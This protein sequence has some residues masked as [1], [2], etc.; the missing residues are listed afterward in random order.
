MVKRKQKIGL[1]LGAGSA[2][3]LAHIGVLKVLEE[4]KIPVDYLAGTSMGALIGAF[5]ATGRGVE[6]M[7]E[8]ATGVDLKLMARLFAPTFSTSGLIEGKRIKEFLSPFLKGFNFQT[9]KIPFAALATD[10]RTGREVVLKEG[11]LVEAV[12]ASISIPIIFTPVRYRGRY[13]ID[14]GTVN[15]VPVNVARKL[16]A[17]LVIAVNVVNQPSRKQPSRRQDS[18]PVSLNPPSESSPL[19]LLHRKINRFIQE[20]NWPKAAELNRIIFPPGG[21]KEGSPNIVDI[22]MQTLSIY[23]YEVARLRLLHDR[24][25]ILIEPDTSSIKT[26]DYHRAAEAIEIGEKAA[27]KALPKI[28]KA[29]S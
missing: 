26:R 7:E 18:P 24:P 8:I 12:R 29:V 23:E 27:R 11:D 10:L 16:G 4:N 9:L 14:G 6:M 28:L 19:K 1:A 15:P 21:E 13:L 22:M 20:R 17:D 5:Y 2:R 3:G 25:E